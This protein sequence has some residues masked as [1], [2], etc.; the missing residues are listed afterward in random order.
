MKQRTFYTTVGKLDRVGLDELIKLL[1]K[2]SLE[3]NYFVYLTNQSI[4]TN[5]TTNW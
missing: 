4:S 3:K 2:E 5:F 1:P